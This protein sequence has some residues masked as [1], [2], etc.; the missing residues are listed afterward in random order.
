[1]AATAVLLLLSSASA[2]AWFTGTTSGSVTITTG[3]WADY[4]SFVPGGSRA[5][6]WPDCQ[7]AQLLPVAS[8]DDDGAI[9]LDFGDVLTGTHRNWP[10]VLRVTSIAAEPLH[11]VFTVDGA[12]APFIG[13]VRL[14][15]GGSVDVLDPE[16]TRSLAVRLA[17]PAD[18]APGSYTG[19]LSVTVA[20][21]AERHDFPVTLS[22][23]RER[24]QPSPSPSCS[25]SAEPDPDEAPTPAASPSESTP[26]APSPSPDP[27]GAPSPS[28]S[29]SGADAASPS[30]EP[31]PSPSP[32]GPGDASPSP[33]PSPSPPPNK[34]SVLFKLSAGSATVLPGS[35]LA[36]AP[37]ARVLPS[38]ALQL[39][40]GGVPAGEPVLFADVARMASAVDEAIGVTLS[41]SGPVDGVVRSVG[42]IDGA[43]C[44]VGSG[45]TV[46]PGQTERLAFSFDLGS[47]AAAGLYQGVLTVTAR[48]GE[49]AVQRSQVP[50]AAT[51]MQA[52]DASEPDQEA[53]Q[54]AA[55][56]RWLHRLWTPAQRADGSAR[57]PPLLLVIPLR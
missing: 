39:D 16:G 6:H 51:V 24:P 18:T 12:A 34:P 2:L 55:L 5:I 14:L 13:Q 22:V 35:S 42:F 48:L 30:P 9:E 10:D 23:L 54:V 26:S 7:P 44:V 41:L 57:R 27:S 40:F 45:L 43:G 1:M 11:L 46:A 8:C 28:P 32:S 53:A 4:L 17:V 31:S 19:T 52:A 49:G 21:V 50:V 33:E 20:G 25:P 15:R 3:V 47:G 38:G 36:G 56:T 29:P 37:V